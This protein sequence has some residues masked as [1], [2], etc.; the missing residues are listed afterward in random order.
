M[1]KLSEYFVKKTAICNTKSTACRRQSLAI[2][3][4]SMSKFSHDNN[5]QGN[6]SYSGFSENCHAKKWKENVQPKNA[7]VTVLNLLTLIFI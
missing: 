6:S 5:D 1:V 3:K 2:Y 7:S 4:M